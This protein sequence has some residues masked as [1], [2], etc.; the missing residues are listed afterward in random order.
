VTWLDSMERFQQRFIEGRVKALRG[1]PCFLGVM[2]PAE[3]LKPL[4]VELC[5][6]VGLIDSGT[7]PE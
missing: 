6:G 7:V 5:H 2:D 1:Q 4:T 3:M